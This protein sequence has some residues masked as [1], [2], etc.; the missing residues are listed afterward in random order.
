MHAA[1]KVHILKGSAGILPIPW[2]P[3]GLPCLRWHA[4]LL[5]CWPC[6]TS[7]PPPI[8]SAP[9]PAPLPVQISTVRIIKSF[10]SDSAPGASSFRANHFKE[11]VYY[12][13]LDP[14]QQCP[15]GPSW[16]GQPAVC[17]SCHARNWASPLAA[18]AQLPRRGAVGPTHFSAES[19]SSLT[20][21]GSI[22]PL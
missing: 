9:A 1:C 12:P 10:P 22:L 20:R 21:E 16:G 14:S 11:T 15:P 5:Q 19:P 3:M 4:Y 2:Q 8:P 18:R 7:P 6:T 13:S 17:R